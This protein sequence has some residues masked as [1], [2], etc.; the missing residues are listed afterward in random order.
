[1]AD[2]D[3]HEI[4]AIALCVQARTDGYVKSL[5]GCDGQ[6]M[7]AREGLRDHHRCEC[8]SRR[9]GPRARLMQNQEF[10]EKMRV[11]QHWAKSSYCVAAFAGEVSA[12]ELQQLFAEKWLD[13]QRNTNASV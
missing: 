3:V 11:T 7:N 12:A 1:M 9:Y 6:S 2:D 10:E 4:P 13:Y 8:G 5:H